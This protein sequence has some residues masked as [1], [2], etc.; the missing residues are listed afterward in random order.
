V[1]LRR[2]FVTLLPLFGTT[3]SGGSNVESTLG[4]VTVGGVETLDGDQED[5]AGF[6]ATNSELASRL[7]EIEEKVLHHFGPGTRTERSIFHPMDEEDAEDMF[8]LDVVTDLPFDEKV[9]CLKAL[10]AE[11]H[12]LLAPVRPLLTIGIV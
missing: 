8:I 7:P 5:V 11:E 3:S 4:L 1:A 9:D 10:L 6:I 2:G 12:E